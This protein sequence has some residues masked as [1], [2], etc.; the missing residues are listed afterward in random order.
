MAL[1]HE[2]QG[3]GKAEGLIAGTGTAEDH[4]VN[5]G[6]GHHIGAGHKGAHAVPEQNIRK[7]RI[8]LAQNTVQGM[9]IL[10]QIAV[11]LKEA[12]LA[13][14]RGGAS[15]T[16]MVVAADNDALFGQRLDEALGLVA[17]HMLAHAVADLQDGDGIP[18]GDITLVMHLSLVIGRQKGA[19]G[20]DIAHGLSLT[21]RQNRSR[22][23]G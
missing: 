20:L 10:H 19:F 18:L 2:R 5:V 23:D 3:L 4:T 21:P 13:L 1:S 12:K 11:V 6:M 8:G 17:A 22:S 16:E 9:Q 7:P 14:G 15:V